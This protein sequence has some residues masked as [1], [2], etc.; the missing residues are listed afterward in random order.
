[1]SSTV[2]GR[3][4]RLLVP[5]ELAVIA[6]NH[7]PDEHDQED[8]GER[9]GEANEDD[10]ANGE[11]V[12]VGFEEVAR[13]LDKDAGHAP[14]RSIC[15]ACKEE[16]RKCSSVVQRCGDISEVGKDELASNEERVGFIEERGTVVIF[17]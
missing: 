5:L 4:R 2:H 6:H 3:A 13:V 12:A 15:A 14:G 10:E 9:D 17:G 11:I 1:M 8:D 16:R 7:E